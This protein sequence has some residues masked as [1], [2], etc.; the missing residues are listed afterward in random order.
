MVVSLSGIPHF[1]IETIKPA[2]QCIYAIVNLQLIGFTF[3]CEFTFSNPVTV[4]A[5]QCA[6]E[7]FFFTLLSFQAVMSKH[8]IHQ[9]T[10]ISLNHQRYNP[11]TKVGDRSHSAIFIFKGI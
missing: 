10:G 5:D 8:H 9:L 7:I 11:A 1:F 3:Q 6:K 2:M 4:T